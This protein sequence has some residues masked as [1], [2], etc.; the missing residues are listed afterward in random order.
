VRV[1]SL[2]ATV[3]RAAL[4]RQIRP[5]P[6]CHESVHGAG[7]DLTAAEPQAIGHFTAAVDPY[8]WAGGPVGTII[9]FITAASETVRAAEASLLPGQ[10]AWSLNSVLASS[11]A[12]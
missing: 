7:P 3:V 5:R 8:R 9:A 12:L 1:P 2:P 10:G 11:T 4:P 6:K